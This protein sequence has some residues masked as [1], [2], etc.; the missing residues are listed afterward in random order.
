MGVRNVTTTGCATPTT[1]PVD[2]RTEATAEDSDW[3]DA[4]RLTPDG[5]VTTDVEIPTT[6]TTDRKTAR[7]RQFLLVDRFAIAILRV[8]GMLEV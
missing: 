1:L 4:V 7:M 3:C 5:P 6:T 2:G 8:S